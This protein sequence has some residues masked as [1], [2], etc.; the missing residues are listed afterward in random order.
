[1]SLINSDARHL[2]AVTGEQFRVP[3]NWAGRPASHQ[4]GGELAGLSGIVQDYA[5]FRLAVVVL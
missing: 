4:H 5:N 1:M 2:R 3:H